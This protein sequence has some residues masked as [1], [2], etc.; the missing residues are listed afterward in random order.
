LLFLLSP[1]QP[2]DPLDNELEDPDEEDGFAVRSLDI[3]ASGAAAR[4]KEEVS[5]I[6]DLGEGNGGCS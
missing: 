5:S 2:L 4:C 3:G 6:I 1:L